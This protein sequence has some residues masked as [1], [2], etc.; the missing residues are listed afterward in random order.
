MNLMKK[1]VICND[2]NQI[3]G[4]FLLRFTAFSQILIED[5][6]PLVEKKRSYEVKSLDCQV[7]PISRKKKRLRFWETNPIT[8]CHFEQ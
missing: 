3:E 1:V 6:P 2:K 8:Q 5:N 4:A 7:N